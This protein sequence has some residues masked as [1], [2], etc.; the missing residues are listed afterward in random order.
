MEKYGIKAF[1]KLK[2]G[3]KIK[4]YPGDFIV[5]EITPNKKTCTT[6]YSFMESEAVCDF[7]SI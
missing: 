2:L 4:T 6:G 5:E 3:G 1:S 7:V